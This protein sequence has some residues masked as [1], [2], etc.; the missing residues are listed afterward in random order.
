MPGLPG[1]DSITPPSHK[2]VPGQNHIAFGLWIPAESDASDTVSTRRM[3]L[4]RESL[5]YR[6]DSLREI[7]FPRDCSDC[8]FLDM[9]DQVKQPTVLPSNDTVSD[10]FDHIIDV[11]PP[12]PGMHFAIKGAA[13]ILSGALN[14]THASVMAKIRRSAPN[15]YMF[16]P[17]Q[18]I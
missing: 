1:P 14:D 10:I 16:G 9:F 18:F 15:C 6:L 8:C 12:A 13:Q 3:L 2:V 11:Q 7:L 4:A 5:M 17:P